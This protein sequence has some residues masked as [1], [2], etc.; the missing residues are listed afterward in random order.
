M[1]SVT[2]TVE[3]GLD[4]QQGFAEIEASLGKLKTLAG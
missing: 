3:L 4:R 2:K 1:P